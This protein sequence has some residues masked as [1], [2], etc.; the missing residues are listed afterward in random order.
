M[1]RPLHHRMNSVHQA[2][3]KKISIVNCNSLKGTV[4]VILIDSSCKDGNARFT[5]VPLL[6]IFNCGFTIQK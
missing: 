2:F 4:S 5:T 6:I 3:F 1:R